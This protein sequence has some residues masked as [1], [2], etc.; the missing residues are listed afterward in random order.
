MKYSN[1][2][3]VSPLHALCLNSDADLDELK[4]FLITHKEEMIKAI[5]APQFHSFHG[6]T[7]LHLAM[8]HG[9][10]EGAILMLKADP[11][12]LNDVGDTPIEYGLQC[13]DPLHGTREELA[14]IFSVD[15]PIQSLTPSHFFVACATRLCEYAIHA[16]HTTPLHLAFE[17][18]I[19]ILLIQHCAEV[20][21]QNIYGKTPLHLVCRRERCNDEA[22]NALLENGADINIED[23]LSRTCLMLPCFEELINQSEPTIKK[24][25][26]LL[27]HI[28]KLRSLGFHVNIKNN[29]AHYLILRN[30]GRLF[31]ENDF[32]TECKNELELMKLENIDRY[33]TIYDIFFKSLNSMAFHCENQILQSIF[34]SNTECFSI[35]GSFIRLQMKRGQARRSLLGNSEKSLIFLIGKPLPPVCL[36]KI[37][38]YLSD[39]E[40]QCITRSG[41][42]G[43]E[44]ERTDRARNRKGKEV[45]T[46][47]HRQLF[48]LDLDCP[49]SAELI[50][51]ANAES[52]FA[53][54]FKWFAFATDAS[55]D[56]VVTELFSE[57]DLYPSSD[58][59]LWQRGQSSGRL[60]SI[61]RTDVNDSLRMEERGHWDEGKMQLDVVDD[62]VASRRRRNLYGAL[63][64]SSL[65]VTEPDTLNHLTDYKDQHVDTI[66]KCNYPWML[67]LIKMM[68]ATVSFR[69]THTWGYMTP[70]GSWDGM[71]GMLDRGEIDIGGTSTFILK[72]RI[73]VVRYIALTTPSRSR[74]I[75]RQPPLS[76]VENLFR[77]PFNNSVWLVIIMLLLLFLFLLYPA[78]RFEWSRYELS[79]HENKPNLSDDLLVVV[80]AASQQGFWYE[81]RSLSTRLVVLVALLAAVSLYAAYT[82]NIVA[83]LQS[84]TSSIN[85]LQDLL[86]SPLDL[87][88]QDTVYYRHYFNHFKDPVR[89]AIFERKVE[90]RG[91]RKNNWLTIEEGIERLRN[92]Y[93][94]FH[95]VAGKVYKI[96]QETFEESEK[97]G[98]QEIDYL[99]VFDP[100]FVAQKRTPYLELFRVGLVRLHECGLRTREM[101]RLYTEKPIC[102]SGR[103]LLSVGLTESYGAFVALGFGILLAFVILV[104][105]FV[106]KKLYVSASL[107]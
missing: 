31:N 50:R 20:N 58:L 24:L 93:F 47:A 78:M 86:N 36:E 74:F 97:C 43:D 57:M 102:N 82:A 2:G 56:N 59:I 1:D 89:K 103:R 12:V 101:T 63:V 26:I 19:I 92:G 60:V 83:L 95:S 62:R 49:D 55:D 4:Q 85:T 54:P 15:T 37:L 70:N 30:C 107:K 106:D 44:M 45:P 39:T 87:G 51:R 5:D 18:G 64:R 53:T 28:K 42:L 69:L 105:E 35:Y 14:T 80:G 94:A 90:P 8:A 48:L 11:H 72:D 71:I 16:L 98:F 84:T 6:L 77:L 7:P 88:A 75:F 66:T 23:K 40:L 52:M 9:N 33:T 13:D 73:S 32:G 91:S 96:I 100:C 65:V 27:K 38:D 68:N 29:A 10:F 3:G 34:E 104:A 22:M 76:S 46:D 41:G 61:Y 17:T 79:G 81:P 25:L 21:V 67:N 99:N